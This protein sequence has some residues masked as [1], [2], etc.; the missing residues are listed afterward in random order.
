MPLEIAGG[1]GAQA[2]LFGV[3]GL[4]PQN[5]RSLT[6]QPAYQPELGTAALRGLRFAGHTYDVE[7]RE[8]GFRVI[9]DQT[10][11]YTG[12]YGTKAVFADA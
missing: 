10:P 12:A 6:V 9:R 3:F 8:D 11:A 4:R 7:L 2:V 5:G 1:G